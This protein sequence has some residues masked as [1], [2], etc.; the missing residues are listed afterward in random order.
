MPLPRYEQNHSSGKLIAWCHSVFPLSDFT[1]CMAVLLSFS[2]NNSFECAIF[3]SYHGAPIAGALEV[4]VAPLPRKS[5]HD[6]RVVALHGH[7]QRGLARIIRLIG[8]RPALDQP[9]C[10]TLHRSFVLGNPRVVILFHLLGG[11]GAVSGANGC[12][13]YVDRMLKCA[14]RCLDLPRL[15]TISVQ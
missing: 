5:R 13:C 12:K 8:V 9:G 3:R 1:A 7:V 15:L 4:D 14:L 10:Q 11:R 6:R 2:L